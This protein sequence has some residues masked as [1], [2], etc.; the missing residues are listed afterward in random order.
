VVSIQSET[1]PPVTTPPESTIGASR[2]SIRECMSRILASGETSG[3]TTALFV[4]AARLSRMPLAAR[5]M[6]PVQTDAT[7]SDA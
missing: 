6:A 4:V 2:A 7:L 1:P 5:I 3:G